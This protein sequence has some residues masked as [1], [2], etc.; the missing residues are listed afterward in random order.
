MI[1]DFQGFFKMF[2]EELWRTLKNQLFHEY[3]DHGNIHIRTTCTDLEAYT[4]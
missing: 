3:E 1:C 4:E 2:I